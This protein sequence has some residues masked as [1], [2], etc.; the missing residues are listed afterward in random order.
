MGF[1]NGTACL[2]MFQQTICLQTSQRFWVS[3]FSIPSAIY[4]TMS[5]TDAFFLLSILFQ[6]VFIKKSWFITDC[7]T[8]VVCVSDVILAIPAA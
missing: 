7:V 6:Q 4:S 2:K 5:H 3:K 1:V 8:E